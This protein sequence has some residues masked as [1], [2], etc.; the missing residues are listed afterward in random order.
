MEETLI[1]SVKGL[2]PD[3]LSEVVDFAQ[4]LKQKKGAPPLQKDRNIVYALAGK[5]KGCS[6]G[7]QESMKDK[8]KEKM[9]EEK[10]KKR[11]LML[12]LLPLLYPN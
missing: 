10:K 1:K 7:T 2:P 4:F 9:L 11:F 8:L 3:T 12:I 6:S 5:Y